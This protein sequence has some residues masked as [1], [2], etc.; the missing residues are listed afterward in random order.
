[1]S[2]P[3]GQRDSLARHQRV[4]TGVAALTAVVGDHCDGGSAIEVG[5]WV[6]HQRG[7]S[8]VDV[9]ER[10]AQGNG[11]PT[12]TGHSGATATVSGSQATRRCGR[13][14]ECCD[15]QA[16]ATSAVRVGNRDQ[17]IVAAGK[18]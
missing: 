10:S 11:L 8:R 16:I 3:C 12:R 5:C 4:A 17:P 9:S 6:V 7:Q 2:L 18:S 15:Q 14:G 13:Q 1:M